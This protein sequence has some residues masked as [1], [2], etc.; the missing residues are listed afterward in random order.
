MR[1]AR[2]R[3]RAVRRPAPARLKR[4]L[5]WIIVFTGSIVVIFGVISVIMPMLSGPQPAPAPPTE[6]LYFTDSK[7]ANIRSKFMQRSSEK[8]EVS[9][10]YPITRHDKI[11][12]FI[13]KAI[14]DIDQEFQR[15]VAQHHVF[16][17]RMTETISYQVFRNDNDFLSLVVSIKQDNLGAHPV[18][19]TRFWTFDKHTEKVI[20]MHDVVA[21]SSADMAAVTQQVRAYA[22][23][24]LAERQQPAADITS[25]IGEDTLQ[26]FIAANKTTISF[27][28]GRGELLPASYGDITIS[29]Q[30]DQLT[31][32]LQHPLAKK[33][34]DVPE[35][36]KETPPAPKPAP[37]PPI[38]HSA[39]C[40]GP[41]VAL[42][43]DDGPGAPTDRLLTILRER[44]AKATFFM[45]GSRVAAQPVTAKNVAEAGHEIGNHS[46]SHSDLARLTPQQIRAE[47]Q[48]TNNT[49]KSVTGKQPTALRPPYGSSNAA[50]RAEVANAGM[51]SVLWSVDTRDWA[52]RNAQVICSRAV[53]NARSG[54]IILLHDIHATSVDAVPCIVDTLKKQGYRFV[55]TSTILG[56]YQPGQSYHSGA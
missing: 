43:F 20:T 10:E 50:V 37:A 51:A 33:L 30:V 3:S 45:L 6:K 19:S 52:D 40:G 31:K 27:P 39:A 18:S 35:P 44:D 1:Q 7:Y 9:I 48:R 38:A 42:T 2:P 14:N 41:C 47:I 24:L 53:S 54:S 16:T 28:F 34:F 49:I 15:L 36:P 22:K 25:E 17:T 13:T 55:T 32:H 46:W 11:N 29:L 12:D 5:P 23:K 8:E 56:R 4:F 21:Q 26:Q